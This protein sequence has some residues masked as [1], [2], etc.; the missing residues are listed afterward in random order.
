MENSYATLGE[1]NTSF[2]TLKS[3][4]HIFI[5]LEATQL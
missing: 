2:C 3:E 5:N 4:S 1:K